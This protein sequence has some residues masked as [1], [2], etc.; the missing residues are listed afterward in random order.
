VNR[1]GV[2]QDFQKKKKTIQDLQFA[3]GDGPPY[4]FCGGSFTTQDSVRR[5]MDN[6]ILSGTTAI[7]VFKAM[8]LAE[9][10]WFQL[11]ENAQLNNREQ[12]IQ[13]ATTP[14][15]GLRLSLPY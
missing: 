4:K 3:Y 5:I 15:L 13:L 14:V 2:K 8:A 9:R 6:T 12:N 10:I 7:F 1:S 11:S